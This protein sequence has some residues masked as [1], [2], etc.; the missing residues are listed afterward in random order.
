MKPV[1]LLFLLMTLISACST[2]KKSSALAL[3]KVKTAQINIQLGMGYLQRH[4]TQ[5]AKTKFLTALEY[6]PEMPE[7]WYAMG[8]FLESTGN[9]QA[10]KKYYEKALKLAPTRGDVQNN[11]GTYLCRNGAY[12]AAIHHFQLAA[13]DPNYLDIASAYENAGLCAL[14][15][16]NKSLAKKFFQQALAEDAKRTVSQQ[17]LLALEKES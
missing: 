3:N 9:S 13:K 17:A 10:A 4:D 7:S 1:V 12:Q 8:Y 2:Q 16:P 5:R 6:G 15:M 11:Y 14:K